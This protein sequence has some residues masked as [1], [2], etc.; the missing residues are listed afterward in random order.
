VEDNITSMI[1][2]VE[3]ERDKIEQKTK[4]DD[5]KTSLN[6]YGSNLTRMIFSVI[7]TPG[8]LMEKHDCII[9]LEA[10]GSCISN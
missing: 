3:R 8:G 1:L 6:G 4:K 7:Y 10:P 5:T 2:S 9:C